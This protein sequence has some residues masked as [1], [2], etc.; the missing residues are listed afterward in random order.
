MLYSPHLQYAESL[1]AFCL[2]NSIENLTKNTIVI[3]FLSF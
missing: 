3:H 2:H 1:T